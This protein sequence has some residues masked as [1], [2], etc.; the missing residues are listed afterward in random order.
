ML[1]IKY[2]RENQE[3][4]RETIKN[5]KV[6]L[7]LNKL[8]EVDEERR[9]LIQK[10]ESIRAEQKKTQDRDQG[11]KLKNEFKELE[12]QLGGIEKI[13][14]DLIMQVPNIPTEDTPV[15]MSEN[16]NVVIKKVGHPTKFNFPIKN[17]WELAQQLDLIDKERAAKVSGSRFAYLKGD[18]VRLQFA[19]L[20]FAMDQ[21]TNQKVLRKIIKDN[22]LNISDKSFI[23]VLPPYLIKTDVYRNTGRL[24]SAEVT[25]KI[26]GEDLWLNAS[27][28]HS[29]APMYQGEII[30]E[31]KLPIRYLGYTTAFRREAGTYGKDMEGI[32]R[33]HQFD[34]LEMEVFSTKETA[35]EEHKFLI[36]IQE[37]LMQQLE[38]PY[39]VLLK[40]TA[41][42]GGP[43]ARGV[44]VEAWM[45]GQDK[46]RETHTADYMTDFQARRLQIRVRRSTNNVEFVHT[47]DAT[48]LSQR[49]LIAILENF[50]QKD[51][52]IKIPKVLRQYTGFKE[53]KSKV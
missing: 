15:G 39:Q 48:A 24:N 27:A 8:L 11:L 5:K 6:D 26:E 30:E 31:Q 29:L 33:M 53:I 34:K 52:S 49:P 19:M 20:Q 12:T 13:F 25:Y 35:L 40:C 23:L 36:A 38:I 10:S 17:H 16:D 1:D 28:E 50:Q 42:I 41:E 43:N 44:D 2:I 14:I 37:Y 46:Y 51:S 18:L 32:L 9:N 3:K 4:I 45:P 7:D 21:L 47:N 22:K